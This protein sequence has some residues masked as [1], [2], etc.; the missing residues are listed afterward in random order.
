MKQIETEC[1]VIVPNGLCDYF[2]ILWDIIKWCHDNDI[3][4]GTGRG[5]VCGS[6]VA[7]CLHITDV[8][9]LKYG[10][11]FERFLNE[12]RVSG[13]RAKSADSMPDIDV[14]F[15]TEF[16]D[17]VKEYIKNKYGYAYTCSIGTYTRMK[18]KTCIK[19]FGKVK[20]LSFDLTNKLTKDID[21]QIEYTW[22]DLIE[23][24]SKS[25]LLFKFVQEYPELVHLTKYALLQPKAE[26]V[27]PSAVVIVPK[28]R[29]DD[30][31]AEIDLCEWMPVKKIDG[32]LV[33]EWEGK[34]ID[35][36]G[37]LKEDILG[38]SQLDKF[39]SILTLIK[40]NTGK[41]ID[42]NKIPL[43][44][45]ATFR[46]FKRGW[47]EDVFQ[48]GTTGLMNYCRQVKPDTLENLIAMTALFRPGPMEMNAHGDFSD[49]KNGKKKP[50]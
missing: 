9:P 13:E 29:V 33:S 31:N 30:S 32:A 27:H 44:D 36:S 20:G 37:F 4:V 3:Y 12:T 24:A 16:R 8:D 39:K 41:S 43:D 25:K 26:S 46:Y 10:L 50:V 34:Y 45:E 35:K 23:Y 48:F 7:Y 17:A 21:D 15:P 22:G 5:S 19:D 6:L 40:K 2:M 28:F 18:L 49:I 38:L 47:N 11:M 14:D 42:V 1:S